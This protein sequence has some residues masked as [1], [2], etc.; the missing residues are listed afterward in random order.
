MS[1]SGRIGA[2]GV[3]GTR[4]KAAGR[5]LGAGVDLLDGPGFV[6]PEAEVDG[7][8]K[9]AAGA[10][11]DLAH[12]ALVGEGVLRGGVDPVVD[13]VEQL[14]GLAFGAVFHVRHVGDGVVHGA[15]ALADALAARLRPFGAFDLGLEL[16]GQGALGDVGLH[17]HGAAQDAVD[18]LDGPDGDGQGLVGG[19]AA[20]ADHIGG[21]LLKGPALHR[22]GQLHGHF[23]GP[24]QPAQ[25]ALRPFL[26]KVSGRIGRLG[27][28]REGR[29]VSHGTNVEHHSR[30]VKLHAGGARVQFRAGSQ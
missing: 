4:R 26:A 12:R 3:R 8:A 28:F 5:A 9:V 21:G 11:D 1:R 29:G 7:K 30:K 22:L 15:L 23:A 16:A 19:G 14:L 10:G 18:A 13:G 20:L 6:G 27:S 24:F 2:W 25:V 17:G